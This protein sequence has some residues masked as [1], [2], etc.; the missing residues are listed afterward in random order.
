MKPLNGYLA[1]TQHLSIIALAGLGCLLLPGYS[2]AGAEPAAAELQKA[3]QVRRLTTQEAER[4]V[5][6]R[7]RGV[8]TFF[9][10]N[11]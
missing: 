2:G 3:E 11:L 7:L 6:V 9:D 10:E 8:V 1:L 5:P 4:S